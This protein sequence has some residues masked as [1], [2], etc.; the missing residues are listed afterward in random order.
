M[1]KNL[2][3]YGATV[4][5]LEK[6]VAFYQDVLHMKVQSTNEESGKA[7]EEATGFAGAH[8]K[9]AILSFEGFDHRR[10]KLIQ[11]LSP[12]G[13]QTY[14][15]KF[16]DVGSAHPTLPP[17]GGKLEEAY[18]MLRANGVKFLGPRIARPAEEFPQRGMAFVIDPDGLLLELYNGEYH[19]GHCVSDRDKLM[20]FYGYVLGLLPYRISHRTSK[21]IE[22][23]LQVPGGQTMVAFMVIEPNQAVEFYSFPV[24]KGKQ[25]YELKLCDVGSTHVAFNV[26]DIQQT[27]AE[28]KAKGA[29]F[30]SKP[31]HRE[32]K[33]EATM[34]YII[35]PDGYMLELRQEKK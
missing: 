7:L 21:E 6:S 23:G 35:D 27:H 29:K 12:K 28:L 1:L 17:I 4:S 15:L 25:K 34:A 16:N 14:D 5:N 30:I 22:V 13:K 33:S 11:Y 10:I 19:L 2:A 26:D 18:D 20:Y 8:I 3:Y 32:E 24:A 31:I 9:E